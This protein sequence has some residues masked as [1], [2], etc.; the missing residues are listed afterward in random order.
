[1]DCVAVNEWIWFWP[2]LTGLADTPAVR[3][4]MSADSFLS[5]PEDMLLIFRERAGERNIDVR[6]KY[7]LQLV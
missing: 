1:M 4:K 6:E 5:L 3:R 7:Q 2:W